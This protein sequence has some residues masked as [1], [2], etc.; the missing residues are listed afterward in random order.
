MQTKNLFLQLAGTGKIQDSQNRGIAG[1]GSQSCDCKAM[2]IFRVHFEKN[3][4]QKTLV[5]FH[6]RDKYPSRGADS[7]DTRAGAVRLWSIHWYFVYPA[8]TDR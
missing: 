4:F 1:D 5:R 8:D 7:S 2:S 3:W 6:E